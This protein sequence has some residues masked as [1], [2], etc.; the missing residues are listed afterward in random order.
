MESNPDGKPGI[1][2]FCQEPDIRDLFEC[3]DTRGK[4]WKWAVCDSCGARSLVPR[5]SDA[6]LALAYDSG[7][8]GEAETKFV[9]IGERFIEACRKHRAKRMSR[10]LK[11]GSRILDLGCGNGGF[12]AALGELGIFSLHGVEIEGGSASRAL[13]R[14]GM[15]I[16]IGQLEPDDFAPESLDLVTLFHV[17]EH[18]TN[19]KKTLGMIHRAM[20][21][22]SR[23]VMSFPNIDSNQ[24]RWFKGKW[25]HLDPPRHL[26]LLP[27][28]VFE[29]EL[30]SLGFRVISKRFFSVE[31][32]PFGLIQ[33][34]LNFFGFPRDLL[35]E[36][37]KGNFGYAASHG[38]LSILFQKAFCGLCLGPAILIDLFE[39]YFG[40]SAT[41]EY[42]LMKKSVNHDQ[43]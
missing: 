4:S 12:L 31:Q 23:L 6:D 11:N 32:N 25:L 40:R 34:L 13:G 16:K 39:S 14:K 37:L 2:G 17:F 10:M 29:K 35:F 33:S 21:P 28:A 41:V 8:Y 18:L 30:D 42:T 9:G 15:E 5:P 24:A 20:H 27:G 36:R 19:P 7:Y 26:F 3:V 38:T 22:D 43:K 1:C